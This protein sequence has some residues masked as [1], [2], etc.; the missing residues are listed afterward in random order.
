MRRLVILAA[1]ATLTACA[2]HEPAAVPPA[3]HGVQAAAPARHELDGTLDY[4]RVFMLHANP[5]SPMTGASLFRGRCSTPSTWVAAFDV[6]GTLTGVGDVRGTATHCSQITP[7]EGGVSVTYTD[8]HVWL[9]TASGEDLFVDYGNGRGWMIDAENLAYEDDWTI[10]G[11]TGDFADLRGEGVDEGIANVTT[12]EF[13][14]LRMRGYT[15]G[16]GAGRRPDIR[17]TLT[18]ELR[19][20]YAAAG[21][22][23]E[24]P[25]LRV[26]GPGWTT[27][28]VTGH[29][30]A[31]LLGTFTTDG[32]AC[33]N[34]ATGET[35]QRRLRGVTTRGDA[36][37]LDVIEM[38]MDLPWFVPGVDR[39]Y[40]LRF[41]ERL[42]GRTGR[43]QG[44]RAAIWSVGE[45]DAHWEQAGDEP[46]PRFPWILRSDLTG[47]LDPSKG[48]S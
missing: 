7:V 25:C 22:T 36:F 20:P 38:R 28:T 44:V 16:A 24:D 48:S 15:V 18:M 3:P 47:W 34:L 45:I 6:M 26:P 46:A 30:R 21:R 5:D 23:D 39:A 17:G 1:C 11:G 27:V 31:T 10:V 2:A 13:P 12:N 43:L 33:M 8:G 41:E 4:L 37:D 14:P 42:A 19:A 9:R 29:G 32:A 40:S 35:S